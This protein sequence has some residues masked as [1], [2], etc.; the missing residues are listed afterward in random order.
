MEEI[1]RPRDEEDVVFEGES[2]PDGDVD[3]EDIEADAGTKLK[4]LKE[5]LKDAEEAKRRALEDLQRAKADFLNSRKRLEE[6]LERDRE[7]ITERHI[8]DILPLADSFEMAMQ[9]PSWNEADAVWRRGVEGIYAQLSGLL[10]N[11][12]VS[13]IDAVGKPFNPTEH[14]AVSDVKVVDEAK[15]HTVVQVL[16]NG[17]KRKDTVVRPAR[18]VVGVKG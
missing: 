14:E 17:Y 4:K 1:N 10:R 16:Q 11:Y 9:D 5:K 6:Q 8:E 2:V 13:K 12:G 7:R 18:V 3:L 15:D